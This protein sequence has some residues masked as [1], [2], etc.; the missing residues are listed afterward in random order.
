[1]RSYR[2]PNR[3]KIR[4]WKRRIKQ[5]ET[6]GERIKTPDL[7]YFDKP[8]GYT[9]DRC[10]LY[11]FY[12]LEKRQPPLWFYKLIISKF[13]TAYFEWEKVFEKLN[14]PYDLQLW[15]YDPNYMWSEIICRRV[16]KSGDRIGY[17][18]GVGVQKEF[19]Y[20]KFESNTRDDLKQ[21]HLPVHRCRL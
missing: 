20:K 11:P 3:K 12:V 17:S 5:I 6:W 21:L 7:K 2:N 14:I 18:G 13:I 9:H 16:A 19:P 1:M 10:F 15:I 8:G 4:G